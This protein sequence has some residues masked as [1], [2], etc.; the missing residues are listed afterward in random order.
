MLDGQRGRQAPTP[1]DRT[2]IKS[3]TKSVSPLLTP[4]K[5]GSPPEMIAAATT[6]IILSAPLLTAKDAPLPS[7]ADFA[8]G[9]CEEKWTRVDG[10]VRGLAGFIEGRGNLH[11]EVTRYT[12]SLVQAVL[13]LNK[14]KKSLEPTRP[15]TADKA[16]GTPPMFAGGMSSKRPAQSPPATR[17]APK[18]HTATATPGNWM[19]T[20]TRPLTKMDFPSSTVDARRQR[21]QPA[22]AAD[23]TA[24]TRQQPKPRPTTRKI[25]HR[26]DAIVIKARDASTYASILR[27][28][29]SEQTLQQSVGSSVQS[30]RRSAAGALVLQL[31]RGVDNASYLGAEVGRVLGDEATASAIQHTTTVE[32][33]DL[34]EC[35][36]KKEIAEELGKSLGAPHLKEDVIKTLRKAYAGTQAAVAALPD[37]LA[38]KALKLGHIRIG[39]VNCRIRGRKDALRCYA[40]GAPATSRPAPV[41]PS[42]K[43]VQPSPSMMRILQLNLNHCRAAQDLLSQTILEQNI[44]VAVLCDQYMNLDPPYWLADANNQAA[45]WVHGGC[46]LQER[47]ARARPFFTWARING[48]YFFSVYAPPRLADAEFSALLANI[49]EEARDKRPLIVAGD[50][51]AWSTEWGCRVT[52]WRATALLD[53]FAALEAVLL[54]NTGDMPTFRCPLGYSVIDLTLASDTLAPQI[55]S[56]AVSELYTHSDHQ[57][58]VFELKTDRPPRPSTRQS[59]KWNAHTLDTECLSVMMAGTVVPP[60]PA[61]E[62]ATSLMAAITSACDASMTKSGG[63]RR[64]GAVYCKRLCWN[65]LCDEVN[66]DVWGKPYETVMSRLRGPRVNSPSSPSMVRRIVAALFPHVPDEPA[67]PPPLQAGAVVPAVT[68]EELR[69]ACRRIKNHTAPAPDGVPNSAIKLAID[70]HPDIFMQVYTVCLRTGVFPACWKR[71][72][73]VLLPKPGKPPEEPSSYRPLCMLDTAGKILER[74]ICDRLEAIT[75]RA[76]RASRTTSTASGRGDRRSTPSRTSSLPLE[77]LSRSGDG[78]AA[79]RNTAPSE[80]PRLRHGRR[81]RVLR[82]H[83]RRPQGSVLGPILWNAMYDAVLRLNFTGNVRIVGFADDIALVAVAKHLWQIEYDLSAAIEQVRDTLHELSLVTADH[84]TEALLITS[85]KKMENITI[86]VGDCS[87]RSSPCISYLGLHI[88]SRLRF[89]QHLQTVSEKAARVAGAL[90]RIMPNTGGPR[91]SR[92]ELYARVVDS[93]LL[94]GAPIWRCATE[95]EA[96]IRQAE[97]VHRRACLRV[98]SGRP[99][100]SYDATHSQRY[101]NT[102]SALCP[103]CPSTIENAEHLFFF[104]SLPAIPRRERERLQQVLQEEIEPENNTRLMLMTA[105]KWLAVASF[106]QSVV[107]RLRQEAQEE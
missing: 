67:P 62:M 21:C 6:S 58:I 28:L 61:E 91:S 14:T 105:G 26:P 17:A 92:R 45:I 8:T 86:T 25:H 16:V 39:W 83:S 52:R 68:L 32:I 35:A 104:F 75:E 20:T 97:A 74:I 2:S 56:W 81:A 70:A 30:I 3:R 106:A 44:N 63:R 10:L 5:R 19:R 11:R 24:S 77:R 7:P 49:I 88:D 102:H 22:A 53:A 87:I 64:R 55:T 29:R 38:A 42:R 13:A 65:K 101:D 27:K 57:A 90:A 1:A 41:L 71:Q 31:R 96:Y 18:R 100:V 103:A 94:Y 33:R 51:N 9:S 15:S 60:G 40:A 80:S 34:D 4:M 95:T 99:H 76:L 79:P 59:C 93:I 48:I 36:T 98:I 69:G 12:Q 23:E 78:T 50:F 37:D 72:R 43:E 84:K 107:T 82:S 66:E 89:N 54:L 47:P 46:L 85:R 73:L